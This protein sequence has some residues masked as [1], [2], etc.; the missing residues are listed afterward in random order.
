MGNRQNLHISTEKVATSNA[1]YNISSIQVIL[2]NNLIMFWHQEKYS[3]DV[4]VFSPLHCFTY[5]YYVFVIFGWFF[6]GKKKIHFKITKF[7]KYTSMQINL[8]AKQ[9]AKK[10]LDF[11][12]IFNVYHAEA[13]SVPI[14][15]VRRT[16]F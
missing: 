8:Y 7:V 16:V 2:A 1:F 9:K 11:R 13:L 6:L 3:I 4:H 15:H 5:I 10:S 14:W 12:N